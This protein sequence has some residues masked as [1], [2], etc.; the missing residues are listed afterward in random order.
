M[1]AASSAHFKYSPSDLRS[2]VLSLSLVS[3]ARS[4]VPA[5]IYRVANIHDESVRSFRFLHLAVAVS[6]FPNVYA[7]PHGRAFSFVNFAPQRAYTG[8]RS[9]GVWG[10]KLGCGVITVAP[11]QTRPFRQADSV[12]DTVRFFPKIRHLFPRKPIHNTCKNIILITYLSNYIIRSLDKHFSKLA[13]QL[14]V[15][16]TAPRFL[17]LL[18][19]SIKRYR[20]TDALGRLTLT[21]ASQTEPLT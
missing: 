2:T 10:A 19:R 7:H 21:L 13:T 20:V 9:G 17:E 11:T 6:R 18:R 14:Y 15:P 4:G 16:V 8:C 5:V 12:T 3:S 1:G